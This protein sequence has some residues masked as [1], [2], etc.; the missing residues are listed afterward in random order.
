MIVHPLEAEKF[1]IEEE[2]ARLA[3]R[4]DNCTAS[5]DEMLHLWSLQTPPDPSREYWKLIIG[6]DWCLKEKP[7]T[8]TLKGVLQSIILKH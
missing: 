6:I 7:R 2:V 8:A 4:V 3:D 5:A 1:A